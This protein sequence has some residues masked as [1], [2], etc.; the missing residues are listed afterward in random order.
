MKQELRIISLLNVLGAVVPKAQAFSG[1]TNNLRRGKN[2]NSAAKTWLAIGM[3]LLSSGFLQSWPLSEQS[4]SN[5]D[6]LA[7]Q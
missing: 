1:A 3:V 6:E 5:D 2:M 7:F 4:W